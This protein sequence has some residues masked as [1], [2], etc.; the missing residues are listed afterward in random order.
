M[1]KDPI[2]KEWGFDTPWQGNTTTEVLSEDKGD[3]ELPKEEVNHT[4]QLQV[5]VQYR[6]EDC[7]SYE[8]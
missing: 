1:T 5:W 4:Y 7:N 2:L 3:T 6:N 8:Y